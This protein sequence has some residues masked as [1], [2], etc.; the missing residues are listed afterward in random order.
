MNIKKGLF[1]FLAVAFLALTAYAASM[2]KINHIRAA[3]GEFT[4][5]RVSGRMDAQRNQGLSPNEGGFTKVSLN[6]VVVKGDNFALY[7]ENNLVY[8]L[9]T[10]KFYAAQTANSKVKYQ[11]SVAYWIEV[12]DFRV[13]SKE[14]LKTNNLLQP[15]GQE[16]ITIHAN[17]AVFSRLNVQEKDSFKIQNSVIPSKS[18]GV[19]IFTGSSALKFTAVADSSGKK[20]DVLVLQ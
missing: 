17:T 20:H 13:N 8:F 4:V 5:L 6:D 2:T 9:V 15:Y 19:D 3:N 10:G 7:P 1:V 18:D 12:E 11:P 14:N 16:T